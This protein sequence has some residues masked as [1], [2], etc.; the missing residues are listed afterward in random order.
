MVVAGVGT[1]SLRACLV[2]SVARAQSDL[3]RLHKFLLQKDAS[4]AKR[5]VIAINAELKPLE[6]S[7]A[8]GRP[9]ADFSNLRKLDIDYGS[10]GYLALYRYEPE[11]NVVTI[12][13]IK[14]QKEDDYC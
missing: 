5:A 9:I 4:T 8:I 11:F 6:D 1:E 3:L 7:P 13:A 14:H 12:L 10:T 2:R